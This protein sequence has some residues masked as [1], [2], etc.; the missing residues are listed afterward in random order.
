MQWIN[1]E[2]LNF[3]EEIFFNFSPQ[4]VQILWIILL[5]PRPIQLLSIPTDSNN[6]LCFLK[7][8]LKERYMLILWII[9]QL[10]R[11]LHIPFLP[12]LALGFVFTPKNLSKISHNRFP[13]LGPQMLY[14]LEVFFKEILHKCFRVLDAR[15]LQICAVEWKNMKDNRLNTRYFWLHSN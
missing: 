2:I 4:I 5:H 10:A 8:L 1:C 12:T 15:G 3:L 11:R 14:P 6:N 7:T 9:Q 13:Q